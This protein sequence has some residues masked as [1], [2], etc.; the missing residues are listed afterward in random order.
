M[1]YEVAIG[2]VSIGVL[3]FFLKLTDS[4]D[5]KEHVI[6]KFFLLLVSVWFVPV[7]WNIIMQIAAEHKPEIA[8]PVINS[9]VIGYRVIIVSGIVTTSYLMLYYIKSVFVVWIDLVRN[10]REGNE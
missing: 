10:K 8:T 3:W 6:L 1:T 7:I 2:F 4:I 9:L 5:E